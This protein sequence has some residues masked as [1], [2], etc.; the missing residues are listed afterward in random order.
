[1]PSTFPVSVDVFSP[2]PPVDL[3][4][5]VR[6]N[7]VGALQ[8]AVIAVENYSIDLKALLSD[9]WIPFTATLTYSS[10]DAPSWVISADADITSLLKIGMRIKLTH[11]STVKYF[12]VTAVGSYSGGVTLFTVY[13]G[14][15]YTLTNSAFTLGYYS[16]VKCPA[17]FPMA[18]EKWTVLLIS[19]I[20]YSQANP[21]AGTYY[22]PGTLS[23]VVPIGS[24]RIGCSALLSCS[25]VNTQV[26]MQI[27]LSTT[28]N[29]VT[30]AQLLG[31]QIG[32]SSSVA[33]TLQVFNRLLTLTTKATYNLLV[34]TNTTGVTSMD[35]MGSTATTKIYAESTLL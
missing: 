21:T 30:D 29:S 13:G 23:I 19:T 32:Y 26:S 15:D 18:P 1:M 12:L 14:T 9:G 22:Q 33:R 10:A 25:I 35:I 27:L 11:A 28:T 6:A 4:D 20:V 8:D 17:G 16:P 3:F 24:W 7:D 2:D 5:D 31:Y 34:I